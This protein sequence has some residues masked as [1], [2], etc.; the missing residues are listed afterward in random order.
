MFPRCVIVLLLLI[1]FLPTL[2]SAKEDP[3]IQNVV[4][5]LADDLGWS[6]LGCFGSDL[7]ETPHLDRLAS[8]GVSFTDAY[9][10]SPVC[11]PTRASILTG[12]HPARLHMTIWRESAL[13][14]GNRQLLE[15]V[16]LDSL[17]LEHVTLAEV[18]K[19]AGFYNAHIGKWHLGRAESYPQ[20]HGFHRNVGGTLWGAPQTFW[21]PFSGDQYFRDWRYV[22]D[23]E[24]GELGNY[25]TDELTDA[26]L[27]IMEH[28]VTTK[29]P[30]FLNLWY[31]AV[32]T[33]IE[34]KPELVAKYEQKVTADSVQRNP[35]YAAMVES[36]DQN[37]G[38]VLKRLDELEIA[39]RTLVVFTSDNGGFVNR[40]KLHPDIPV[41][42][43]APLRSGKGSCYEG[44]IRVPLIVRGPGIKQGTSDSPVFSC[45]L[46]PTI[47]NQ[48]GLGDRIPK[49]ID[50]VDLS[51]QLRDPGIPLK[52]KTLYFHYPHYY[53]TTTPVSAVR[54]G[55]WK[56]LEYYEQGRTEL[57]HLGDDLGE[58]KDLSTEKQE[59]VLDLQQRLHGWLKGVDA[60]LPESNPNR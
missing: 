2:S 37:V 53:P 24:P 6:D 16:C 36:L 11:T 23:L 14:R 54:H 17:P 41:A 20:P 56:L 22:P 4:L 1:T 35:H 31:H 18:L 49:A 60:L 33:P 29:R 42:N 45:D 12:K 21:Y 44:G 32:H 48:L 3:P 34:G 50:G 19:E 28:S 15:P 38:R 8:Q 43:N 51:A 55:D 58:T 10:A 39:D 26:A 40:C 59:L 25:L 27:D 52:R 13:N 30:F 7:H 5:I 9:A 47:L 46:Y 57:Y